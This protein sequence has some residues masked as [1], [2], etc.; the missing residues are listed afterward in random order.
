MQEG[1]VDWLGG[2]DEALAHIDEFKLVQ[3]SQKGVSG[4]AVYGL[5]KAEMWRETAKYLLE[6]SEDAMSWQQNEYQHDIETKKRERRV[7]EWE[8]SKA[9]L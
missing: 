6:W 5:L 2:L 1:V 7:Q 3:K 8:K 9:K 4:R